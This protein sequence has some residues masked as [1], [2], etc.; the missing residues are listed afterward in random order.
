VLY[1]GAFATSIHSRVLAGQ[2]DDALTL[3][4]VDVPSF[5]MHRPQPLLTVSGVLA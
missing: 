4:P 1:S 5:P 3:E 2:D